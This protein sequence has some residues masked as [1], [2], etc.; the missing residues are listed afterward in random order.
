MLIMVNLESADMIRIANALGGLGSITLV[1]AAI[2]LRFTMR[3]LPRPTKLCGNAH[4]VFMMLALLIPLLCL[5][6][7][8]VSAFRTM[9]SAVLI[10]VFILIGLIYG[11]QGNFSHF[12]RDPPL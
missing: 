3:D 8:T 5:G 12:Q 11:Q 9:I 2:R 10:S 6:F 1:L 7:A 4:P